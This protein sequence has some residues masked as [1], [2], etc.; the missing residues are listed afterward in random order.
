VRKL[1]ALGIVVSLALVALPALADGLKVGVVD[2]EYVIIKSGKGKAAKK[3]LKGIFDRKQKDLNAKQERLLELK[4]KLETPSD[5]ESP[6]KR[7]KNLMEYQQGVLALQ[8]EFVKSQQDLAKKEMELMKPILATLEK[9]LTE[10]AKAGN[11][12]MIL[13]R[14]QHG[15]VFAKPALDITEEILK[16]MDGA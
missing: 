1:L 14:S 4:K 7:K 5:L 9:V 6:D 12:D 3:K 11:Y 16:K 2:V 8:E 13:T 15:V 10:F